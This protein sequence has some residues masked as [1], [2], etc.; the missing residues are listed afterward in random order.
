MYIF[1]Y[2]FIFFYSN[3]TQYSGEIFSNSSKLGTS[4]L[5][6][7]IKNEDDK[8]DVLLLCDNKG[9]FHMRS[10]KNF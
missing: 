5:S 8:L 9:H 6:E 7:K 2:I 1:N 10:L 3:I 4:L